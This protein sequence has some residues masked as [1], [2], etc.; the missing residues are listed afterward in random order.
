MRVMIRRRTLAPC[1]QKPGTKWSCI[2]SFK[3]S[4]C[5]CVRV[6]ERGVGF[7]EVSGG[8]NSSFLRFD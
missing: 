1:Y 3:Y 8:T 2:W 6:C 5:V 7:G 4:M